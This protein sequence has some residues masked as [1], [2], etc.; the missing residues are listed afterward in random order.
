MEIYKFLARLVKVSKISVNLN[1]II[2]GLKWL[3]SKRAG[4]ESA[5]PRPKEGLSHAQVQKHAKEVFLFLLGKNYAGE[6]F[7]CGGAFKPLLKPGLKIKDIDLWVR[8]RREREKLT[9][10]L[11]DRGATLVRDFFPYC[12]RFDYEGCPVEI[13]YQNVKDRPISDIVHGF[14]VAGCAIAATYSKGK[15]IDS[16]MSARA[17]GSIENQLALLEESYIEQLLNDH[18]PTVLRGIDRMTRFAKETGYGIS[19]DETEQLWDIYTNTYSSD[20]RQRSLDIY[21]E[22]TVGF[23]DSCNTGL[24]QR[25]TALV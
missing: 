1:K 11:L 16:Y 25:A 12:L 20:E 3:R 4:L 22:T 21:L 7:L 8:N 17:R 14:D 10:T 18:T 2:P 15:I 13:T 19:V 9:A 24:I 6:V 23:K 5:S